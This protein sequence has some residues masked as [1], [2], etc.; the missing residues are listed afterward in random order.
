MIKRTSHS[1]RGKRV[2]QF[3][4]TF[5]WRKFFKTLEQEEEEEEEIEGEKEALD[6]IQE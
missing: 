6:S 3:N 2:H 4:G 5:S 1:R